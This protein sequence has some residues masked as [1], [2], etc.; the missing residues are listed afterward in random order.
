MVVDALL[1]GPAA[2]AAPAA[3]PVRPAALAALAGP[4]PGRS[5]VIRVGA[6][7]MQALRVAAVAAGIPARYLHPELEGGTTLSI[8]NA[9]TLQGHPPAAVEQ[10]LRALARAGIRPQYVA[11]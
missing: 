2:P 11:V 3:R 1:R 10:V 9:R 7:G 6:D 4:I 5:A 8:P